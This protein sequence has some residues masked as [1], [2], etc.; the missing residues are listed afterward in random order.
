MPSVPEIGNGFGFV[1]RIKVERK[2]HA[3]HIADSVSHIAVAAEVKINLQGIGN[4]DKK[5]AGRVQIGNIRI[6]HIDDS[7]KVIRQKHLFG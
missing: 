6:S 2:L 1:G 7:G 5:R 3:Q 4:H